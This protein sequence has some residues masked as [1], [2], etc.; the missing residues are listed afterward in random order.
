MTVAALFPHAV[1]RPSSHTPAVRAKAVEAILDDVMKQEDI[2]EGEREQTRKALEDAFEY[3]D[4]GYD[5]AKTLDTYHGWCPDASLVETLDCF[6]GELWRTHREAVAAWVKEYSITPQ[7]KVGDRVEATWG[8]EEI[9]GTI[10][11]ID[12]D[13]AQYT[14]QRTP[15]ENGGAI[16]NFE[17]T[18]EAP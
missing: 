7:F 16:V 4:D 17:D 11:S 18:R 8:Y 5:A 13:V 6:S 1:D 9:T 3:K 2:P 15:D 14:I 10:R 12:T